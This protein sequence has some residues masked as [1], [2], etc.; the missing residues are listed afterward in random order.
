MDKEKFSISELVTIYK[1]D[2]LLLV[3]YLPYFEGKNA[4][5]VAHYYNGE[6]IGEK[7]MSFPVYDSTLLSFVKEAQK[8]VFMDK[9]YRYIYSRHR[10]R[11]YQDEY[12]LIEQ[13]TIQDMDILGGILSKYIMGGM[14]RGATWMEGVEYGIYYRLIRKAQELIVFWDSK[15]QMELNRM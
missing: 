11:N 5:D 8:T 15:I 13:A 4:A 2:V 1:S 9:N 3:R 10:I 12:L 14:T 6:A 7:T